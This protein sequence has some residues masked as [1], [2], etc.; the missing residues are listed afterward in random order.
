MERAIETLSV[1]RDNRQQIILKE[2]QVAVEKLRLGQDV[3]AVLPT[4]YGKSMIFT[5]FAYSCQAV[6]EANRE[7]IS[8]CILVISSGGSRVSQNKLQQLIL[9]YIYILKYLQ[10][11]F[12]G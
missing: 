9:G 5:V 8:T 4:G 12:I 10:S 1:V 2:E 3:L 6:N 11:N 7:D